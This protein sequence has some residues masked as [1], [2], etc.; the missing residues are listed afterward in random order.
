MFIHSNLYQFDPE[1]SDDDMSLPTS[2]TEEFRFVIFCSLRKLLTYSDELLLVGLS[3]VDYRSLN[4]GI[5]VLEL[6]SLQ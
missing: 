1:E 6:Q 5:L 3:H 2:E 4:F